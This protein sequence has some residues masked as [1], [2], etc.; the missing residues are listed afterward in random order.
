MTHLGI[1][2][3]EAATWRRPARKLDPIT[4][5]VW[6]FCVVAL[7]CFTA[8]FLAVLIAFIYQAAQAPVSYGTVMH[9]LFPGNYGLT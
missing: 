6:W 2:H 1:A 9:D 3:M 8:F 4:P 5:R 7:I